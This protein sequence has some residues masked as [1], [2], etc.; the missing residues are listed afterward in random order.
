MCPGR[1]SAPPFGKKHLK[2]KINKKP[3]NCVAH[4]RGVE[5]R[6]KNAN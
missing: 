2:K 5:G 1:V 3:H 4:N 6:V